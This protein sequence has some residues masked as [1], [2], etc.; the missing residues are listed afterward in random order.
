MTEIN[1]KSVICIET[2]VI[3]VNIYVNNVYSNF[4]VEIIFQFNCVFQI[5]VRPI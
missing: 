3:K 4:T 1:C 2:F 5:I